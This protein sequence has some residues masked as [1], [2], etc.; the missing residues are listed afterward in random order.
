M[1]AT[2][3]APESLD[4]IDL[5]D[6]KLHAEH[7]LSEIWRHLRAT[8]P[9]YWQPL[10]GTQPGFWAITRYADA[11]S[12]Y[13]DSD[14]FTTE[15]GN[16]LG[17][18]LHGGDSAAGVM[19]AV[20][21]GT[22]HHEI[23]AI[24]QRAF[25]ARALAA[26]GESLRR[27]VD[28]LLTEA[29]DKGECDF[30][31]DV[32]GNVPLGAICDLLDVPQ[33]DRRYLLSL[34][35]HAWSSDHADAPPIDS[36]SARNEI[37][38]YFADLSKVRQR[39]SRTDVVSL[40]TNATIGGDNL[41]DAELVANC[42]GLMIGGDE[43]G[44]HAISGGLQAL[45][46]HPDEWRR[47]KD[48]EAGLASGAEEVLRWTTPS[49]HS[50]RAATVDV[51]VGGEQIH[52]GDAV[53]VWISSA[54]RDET[55]FPDPDRFDLNRDPNKHLTFA[56]GSHFCLGHLLGRMEVEAVLE[57]LRRRVRSVRQTGPAQRI[58]SSVLSGLSSLPVVL[59]PEPARS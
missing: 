53:S 44:R 13:R 48:G 28:R 12:V 5:A 11:L 47:L 45:L 37:L 33:D 8:R 56:L 15:R 6:P 3:V 54:N 23:R 57:G 22:R 29:I 17:T 25:S 4:T 42:Y 32:A 14:R 16:A 41:R 24:L 40:L 35:A 21:D 31:R 2:T 9:V 34:T 39:S 30:A 49:I 50:G 7:D 36:W 58:Y 18:I 1:T 20:T 51:T 52:A 19:L 55:V 10:R 38:L 59:E 46:D 27:T 43:T 26:I